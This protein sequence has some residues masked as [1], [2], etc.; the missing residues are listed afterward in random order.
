VVIVGH[1]GKRAGPAFYSVYGHI[2]DL[3]VKA[4]E[5]VMAGQE[6]G[7]VAAGATP[8]NGF[9][10]IPHLHFAIYAGP[11]RNGILPGYARLWA[12]R[13]KFSWWREP[14]TFIAAYNRQP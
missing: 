10:K 11:W 8:E 5:Q 9:W 12:G 13:T 14:A 7:R 6:V 3:A 2:R 1:Q 4:G